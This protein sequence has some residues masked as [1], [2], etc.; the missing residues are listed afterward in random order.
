MTEWSSPGIPL[1]MSCRSAPSSSRSG[2]ERRARRHRRIPARRASSA[3]SATHS[4]R[5]RSTVNRWYAFAA[6]E[7]AR[8]PTRGAARPARRPGRAPR[9]PGSRPRPARSSVDEASASPRVPALAVSAR[10]PFERLPDRSTRSSRGRRGE[11]QAGRLHR[12]AASDANARTPS[13]ASTIPRREPSDSTSAAARGAASRR[14]TSLV[15]QVTAR[16]AAARSRTSASASGARRRAR[17]R[18]APGGSA[19]RTRPLVARCSATRASSRRSRAASSIAGSL[20]LEVA[21]PRR[22]QRCRPGRRAPTRPTSSAWRSRRPP[23]PSFRLGSSISAIGP[24]RSSTRR[25]RRAELGDRPSPRRLRASCT[26]SD[27]RARPRASRHQARAAGRAAPVSVST[28]SRASASASF[29]VRNGVPERRSPRPTAGT[30]ALGRGG[31]ERATRA[32]RRAASM[33]STSEPGHSSRHAYEPSA[34]DAPS[35]PGGRRPRRRREQR[36]VDRIGRTQ[37]PNALAAQASGRQTARSR[38]LRQIARVLERVGAGLP[39]ADAHR[40]TRRARPTPCR[41][42]SCRCGRSR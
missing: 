16:P 6:G 38:A 28:S 37:R 13:C 12:R 23:A 7:P 20:G 31:R 25:P 8:A 30:R 14:H 22:A 21:R 42:R 10:M 33:R 17:P 34:T 26:R 19:R 41:H 29:G 9:S 35:A 15:I 36:V 39:G 27:R 4:R 1:P 24:G 2:R 18:P 5:C 11:P 3:H 40:P 32:C